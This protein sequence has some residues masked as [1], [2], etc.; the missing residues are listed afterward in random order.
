MITK[1]ISCTHTYTFAYLHVSTH[2]N[3]SKNSYAEVPVIIQAPQNVSQLQKSAVKFN[4]AANG[5]PAPVIMW[6]FTNLNSVVTVLDS[7]TNTSNSN[8]TTAELDLMNVTV[9]NFGNYSCV[10]VNE[11]GA[12]SAVAMLQSGKLEYCRVLPP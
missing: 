12:D 9:N 5:Y 2:Y 8:S 10:A 7:T 1:Y 11:F 3:I 4:C 6:N